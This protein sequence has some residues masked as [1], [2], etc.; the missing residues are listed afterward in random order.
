MEPFLSPKDGCPIKCLPQIPKVVSRVSVTQ[1]LIIVAKSSLGMNSFPAGNVNFQI[2]RSILWALSLEVYISLQFPD[3]STT[4]I[5]GRDLLRVYFREALD[6]H[7]VV[8]PGWVISW[9]V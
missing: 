1:N 4:H 9:L 3:L 6:F 5:A 8:D 7:F 2:S